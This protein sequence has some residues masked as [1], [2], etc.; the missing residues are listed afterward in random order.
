M[1]GSGGVCCQRLLLG[2][3]AEAIG[4]GGIGLL[5]RLTGVSR[6]T[7]QSGVNKIRSGVEPDGRVRAPG[8]GR[9]SVEET[10]PGIEQALEGLVDPESRGDPMSPSRWTTKEGAR[11]QSRVK[12]VPLT[13]HE[14]H[15]EWT[16]IVHCR[17]MPQDWPSK[18]TSPN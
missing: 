3:A 15:G 14:F 6:T 16:Y 4:R 11:H 10:Q 1:S 12:A 2:A 13:R 9:P 8:A 5:A 17:T 7:V 18:D